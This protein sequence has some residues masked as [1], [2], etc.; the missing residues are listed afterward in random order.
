M[1]NF[2]MFSHD[3]FDAQAV[4]PVMYSKSEKFVKVS[5]KG[6]LGDSNGKF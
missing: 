4:D 1:A 3:P 5:R 6:V 2:S